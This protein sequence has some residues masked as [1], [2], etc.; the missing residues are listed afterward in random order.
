[1]EASGQIHLS[2]A[3]GLRKGWHTIAAIQD[4]TATPVLKLIP[5]TLL[6][7]RWNVRLREKAAELE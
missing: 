2:K 5:P 3:S 6:M 7:L 4:S 1:L